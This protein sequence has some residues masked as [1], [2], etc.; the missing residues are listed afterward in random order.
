M[1]P[2][3]QNAEVT[4]TGL[5][6]SKFT[7]KEAIAEEEIY[8]FMKSKYKTSTLNLPVVQNFFFNV[9][10]I[11]VFCSPCRSCGSNVLRCGTDF[12]PRPHNYRALH[13]KLIDEH[14]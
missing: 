3:P 5:K 11:F 4:E 9:L 1:P 7:G 2:S 8:F 14:W 6:E 13:N 10:M 12:S